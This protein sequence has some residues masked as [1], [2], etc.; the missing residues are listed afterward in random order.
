MNLETLNFQISSFFPRSF[1]KISGMS[2]ILRKFH[3]FSRPGK[4]N[5]KI[6]GLQGFTGRLG[7]L[8]TGMTINY[9]ISHLHA[10]KYIHSHVRMN[11]C[12]QLVI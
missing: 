10:S 11:T 12:I 3:A 9:T 4:V 2:H 6:P 7:T 1:V 8:Y 5:D